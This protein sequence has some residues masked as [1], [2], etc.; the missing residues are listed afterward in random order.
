MV[1]VHLPNQDCALS[2][3][4]LTHHRR[5]CVRPAFSALAM[6]ANPSFF[7][8]RDQWFVW[9]YLVG[10]GSTCSPRMELELRN[11][12]A[13]REGPHLVHPLC[14]QCC[15]FCKIGEWSLREVKGLDPNGPESNLLPP[16]PC[17]ISLQ[18]SILKARERGV[19]HKDCKE[20][21]F[22]PPKRKAPLTL[23][24]KGRGL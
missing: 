16:G 9:A 17:R 15:S 1:G 14:V 13:E 7:V 8:C 5:L 11:V 22:T 20:T 6:G 2:V 23:V 19:L 10:L 21:F 3:H 18:D 12:K 4:E 24:C